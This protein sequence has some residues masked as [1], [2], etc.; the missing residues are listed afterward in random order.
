MTTLVATDLDRTVV[1]SARA[2]GPAAPHELIDLEQRRG[3]AT[4]S[5]LR[6]TAAGLAELA[7]HATWVPATARSVAEYRRLDLAGRLGIAPRYVVCASGG[8]LLVDGLRDPAWTARVADVLAAAAPSDEI[9]DLAARHLARLAPD[10]AGPVRGVDGVLLVGRVR[11]S[12]S[13]L[14]GLEAQCAE[15]GWRTIAHDD[16]VHLLPAPLTKLAAVE[17]VQRR[18]GATR[19]LAAGDSPL[20]AE[21]LGAADAGIQPIDG[22]LHRQGW[23]ATHIAVTRSAGVQAGHE[24]VHWLTAVARGTEP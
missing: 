17:E 23:E 11:C 9:A 14:D 1:H 10:T 8:V 19:L 20:D 18:V 16:K 12:V 22:R 3:V 24:I 15:L 2:A 13:G 21:L 5:M 6:S 7:H 4:A